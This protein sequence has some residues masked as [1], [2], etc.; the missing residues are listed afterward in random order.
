MEPAEKPRAFAPKPAQSARLTAPAAEVAAMLG[1]AEATFREKRLRLERDH[2]F[3]PRLP[4]CN[5]WSLPAVRRWISTNGGTYL[6]ADSTHNDRH[7]HG[8]DLT[9][10]ARDLLESYGRKSA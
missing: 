2:G 3:P 6:P 9:V 8:L 10:E 4:G 7:E 5:R 1:C